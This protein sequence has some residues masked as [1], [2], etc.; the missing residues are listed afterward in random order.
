M[1]S[2]DFSDDKFYD[3]IKYAFSDG[4]DLRHKMFLKILS[5]N[6]NGSINSFNETSFN[7]NQ[8]IVNFLKEKS[9]MNVDP[10]VQEG[11][12]AHEIID[13][14]K[15]VGLW[16]NA[17]DNTQWF[18]FDDY[19][20]RDIKLMTCVN[21][22][23]SNLL[24]LNTP[25]PALY[26]R[27]IL[28]HMYYLTF[29]GRKYLG[30]APTPAGVVANHLSPDINAPVVQTI[31][32]STPYLNFGA[33]NS[34]YPHY[35]PVNDRHIN[36]ITM[37]IRDILQKLE[38]FR[39]WLALR[40]D[41]NFSGA[42]TIVDLDNI[43]NDNALVYGAA[44]RGA[45]PA[46][47]GEIA[48]SLVA[49][50][51]ALWTA[52]MNDIPQVRST[53]N[54]D[55]LFKAN[56]KQ[57]FD[58]LT[59][60]DFVNSIIYMDQNTP[61]M[62]ARLFGTY[63]NNLTNELKYGF[64]EFINGT[65][66]AAAPGNDPS[67][68]LA[69]AADT[70]GGAP[71][72]VPNIKPIISTIADGLI[73]HGLFLNVNNAEKIRG[74]SIILLDILFRNIDI[75]VANNIPA[76]TLLALAM[77]PLD[78]KLN[79]YVPGANNR[80]NYVKH[81]LF[82]P[83]Q[84]DING[85]QVNQQL[86]EIVSNIKTLVHSTIYNILIET[87]DQNLVKL[88]KDRNAPVIGNTIPGTT[89]TINQNMVYLYNILRTRATI[90]IGSLVP[91]P[92][93]VEHVYPLQ[94]YTLNLFATLA[95]SNKNIADTIEK[96][97]IV[98]IPD[99]YYLNIAQIALSVD[100]LNIDNYRII[101]SRCVSKIL[102]EKLRGSVIK[103]LANLDQE[104]S[105]A[106]RSGINKIIGPVQYN[107]F[108]EVVSKNVYNKWSRLTQRTRDFYLKYFSLI[109]L[110]GVYI[111]QEKYEIESNN[112]N[113]AIIL[114]SDNSMLNSLHN[115]INEQLGASHIP[116]IIELF[117]FIDPVLSRTIWYTSD[118]LDSPKLNYVNINDNTVHKSL[119]QIIYSS[120]YKS[121]SFGK[122]IAETDYGMYPAGGPYP[123]GIL[124]QKSRYE[125]TLPISQTRFPIRQIGGRNDYESRLIEC[126]HKL[127]LLLNNKYGIQIGGIQNGGVVID[128]ALENVVLDISTILQK[129][130]QLGVIGTFNCTQLS[131]YFNQMLKYKNISENEVNVN[132]IA[133]AVGRNRFIFDKEKQEFYEI[134]SGKKHYPHD[135]TNINNC[136]K[137]KINI[138]DPIQCIQYI[139]GCILSGN[140]EDSHCMEIFKK[141]ALY[142]LTVEDM[143]KALNPN[144]ALRILNAFLFDKNIKDG[145][146]CYD[147]AYTWLKKRKDRE[148][149][150]GTDGKQFVYE[151]F[152]SNGSFMQYLQN[153]VEY[154]NFYR[155]VKRPEQLGGKKNDPSLFSKELGI[156]EY[157]IK[158]GINGP[159]SKIPKSIGYFELNSQSGGKHISQQEFSSEYI[160]SFLDA[161]I[162]K[163]RS[164]N[165][166]LTTETY[167]DIYNKLN[168]LKSVEN[169]IWN[170][171][172]KI[173]TSSRIIE[174]DLSLSNKYTN[175]MT[176]HELEK[177]NADYMHLL[178]TQRINQGTLVKIISGLESIGLNG[179][180][181]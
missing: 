41:L 33:A 94:Q 165:K 91:V 114:N 76:P 37:T 87:S 124:L 146:V 159:V 171:I 16:H 177:L 116:K 176:L 50:T 42:M 27:Q 30:V 123:G 108:C 154:V 90:P 80:N 147:S 20:N 132:I 172:Q 56:L 53:I 111:P 66:V 166:N 153:L 67:F 173:Q 155:L 26:L 22:I 78:I 95:K 62:M 105:S 118:A 19:I 120:A 35:T 129:N 175:D 25:V 127:N 75:P 126:E 5:K 86:N 162:R 82:P 63:Y 149:L 84:K 55:S 170:I 6:G 65:Y 83:C 148:E 79:I 130:R 136:L 174:K 11:D 103:S 17:I 49:A 88:L 93:G 115:V 98:N 18:N 72:I 96:M 7:N 73:K 125:N 128:I 15:N 12:I 157:N 1:T 21:E 69:L 106:N 181:I 4:S 117:P 152:A 97:S 28:I 112:N 43:L 36:T 39:S 68:M 156:L 24:K 102:H 9:Y 77:A 47:P 92:P 134:I 140:F 52:F 71:L 8:D 122:Q 109:N 150:K 3:E 74:V 164:Y 169:Q 85:L 100:N 32:A 57:Y 135:E 34:H 107:N 143:R 64:H 59:K 163:L 179:I 110:D 60:D 160:K 161:S 38:H 119:L 144:T 167:S 13:Y 46:G 142:G 141:N 2:Y 45:G 58:N 51:G 89:T 180:I 145:S 44:P 99:S 133:S 29:V 131:N 81:I 168:E 151:T 61:T 31:D 158:C 10:N 178:Q 139:T 138:N 113:C 70:A 23:W 54:L 137:S 48:A 121:G 14:V 101:L 40:E 104:K